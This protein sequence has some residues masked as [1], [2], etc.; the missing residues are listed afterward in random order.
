[1]KNDC[2]K[3]GFNAKV[4][5]ITQEVYTASIK[6][7]MVIKNDKISFGNY[8][9]SFNEQGQLISEIVFEANGSRYSHYDFFRNST[10][11]IV[12]RKEYNYTG[13]L[14][15]IEKYDSFGNL[16]N[17]SK[18]NTRR[19]YVEYQYKYDSNNNLIESLEFNAE[20]ELDTRIIYKFDSNNNNIEQQ[21]FD[22]DGTLRS[23]AT[24]EF[25][26]LGLIVSS[27]S[28][29]YDRFAINKSSSYEYDENNNLLSQKELNITNNSLTIFTFR[30]KYDVNKNWIEKIE[31]TDN[32]PE[33][34][35]SR[36][37]DY[38]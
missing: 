29:R 24:C 26:L 28:E 20:E 35:K 32:S 17:I 30:Y 22:R 25:N 31:L 36:K 8:S 12:E 11:N 6:G 34:Y 7:D 9:K 37:I 1:M 23:K 38:F 21:Y 16:I 5:V 4:K 2:Q 3:L 15:A 33:Y 14:I 13:L 27:Q 18:F 10:G 19:K